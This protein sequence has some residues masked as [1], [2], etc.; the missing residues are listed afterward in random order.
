MSDPVFWRIAWK[1]YRTQR[2]LW[3]VIAA[4][5][6]FLLAMHD[7]NSHNP[8]KAEFL[9]STAAMVAALFA[10]SS[11]ATL[12]ARE[13]ED[14]TFSFLRQLPSPGTRIYA[15]KLAVVLAGVILVWGLLLLGGAAV[16]KIGRGDLFTAVT[17]KTAYQ[18][19]RWGVAVFEALA[20]GVLCS[21]LVRRVI[22]AVLLA[23]SGAV[24]EAVLLS[25]AIRLVTGISFGDP[26]LLVDVVGPAVVARL[27][28]CAV[29]LWISYRQAQR[30]LLGPEA[31]S[32]RRRAF[33][34]AGLATDG[35]TVAGATCRGIA[36][37]ANG[38]WWR[39]V[40]KW[41]A[42][43]GRTPGRRGPSGWASC[44]SRRLACLQSSW[45]CWRITL[46]T[47]GWRI[48]LATTGCGIHSL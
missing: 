7:L 46:A 24:V 2:A 11:T 13:R 25:V 18:W 21:L 34:G 48:T 35:R 32:P 44:C 41:A 47:T 3:I 8:V 1:E 36:C 27:A 6:V 23:A 37:P 33:G 15:A 45:C 43:V 42:S 14:E 30:Q 26:W 22:V 28:A 16:W 9:V 17:L 19:Q 5:G 20:W 40:A 31:I 29:V 38:G 39:W 12:F 4:L 10:L